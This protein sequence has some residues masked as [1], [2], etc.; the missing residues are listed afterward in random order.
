MMKGIEMS[1]G[2]KYLVVGLAATGLALSVRAANITESWSAND[3]TGLSLAGGTN[4]LPAGDLIEIGVFSVAPTVGS[5]SLANFTAFSASTTA[6]ASGGD[7]NGFW[8]AVVKTAS[9]A[10]FA[11]QQAYMVAFN[12]PTAGAATQEGIYYLT[13]VHLAPG[14]AGQWVFQSSADLNTEAT[15]DIEDLIVSPGTA[16]ATLAATAHIVFGGGPVFDSKDSY[17]FLQ[18]QT[19]PEPSTYMLVGTGL[20]GLLGLR[21]R[22]S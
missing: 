6:V 19:V 5:P 22:R 17:T 7:P 1:K 13:G 15:P 3:V 16:G 21:R 12:A 20:L 8:P 10:G 11:S 4:G 9:D 18:L 2:I 14:A